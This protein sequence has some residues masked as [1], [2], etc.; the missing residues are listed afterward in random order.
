MRYSD[1]LNLRTIGRTLVTQVGGLFELGL[2]RGVRVEPEIVQGRRQDVVGGVQH[3]D[4]A[5]LE[6]GELFRLEHDVPVG[7]RSVDR[8]VDLEDVAGLLD[9]VADARRAPHVID[10]VLIAR[11]VDREPLADLR[12]DIVEVREL[13]LVELLEHAGLDLAL[14]E[15]GR[16]HH[17]V[18]AR[19]AGEE[20]GFQRLVG[21]EGVVADLD[22]GC[23]A[24]GLDH[25][26]LNIVRPVVDVDDPLL[27]G[28]RAAGRHRDHRHGDQ[29]RRKVDEQISCWRSI[30][31]RTFRIGM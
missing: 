18:V 31:R 9:V 12:P 17:H 5:V 14:E 19:F 22:A 16:R 30:F 8:P 7:H 27:P 20:L 23:L 25:G 11:I 6:P 2:L 10:G 29:A 4:A 15:I 21:V 1:E 3:V 28:L 13:R 24:E 26:R